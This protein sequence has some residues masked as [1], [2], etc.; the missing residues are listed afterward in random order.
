MNRKMVLYMIGQVMKVEGLLML[1]P[2]G[3]AALYTESC[4]ISLLISAGIAFGA[5]LAMTVFC[6]TKNRVIYAKEGFVIVAFA[7]ILMSA[8]GA[9]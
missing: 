4:V 8:I 9:L 5:G 3:V 6:K 2:A 7:W 1:L